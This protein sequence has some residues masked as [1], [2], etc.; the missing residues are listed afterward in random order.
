MVPAMPALP[1]LSLP[2]MLDLSMP[3][4]CIRSFCEALTQQTSFD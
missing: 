4:F 1:S 2:S 3:D